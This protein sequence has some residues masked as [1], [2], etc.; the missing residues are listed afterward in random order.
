MSKC[1]AF[2]IL[3]FAM[4]DRS[5]NVCKTTALKPF[6]H[7]NCYVRVIWRRCC[8]FS[9]VIV[10]AYYGRERNNKPEVAS[11]VQD[12]IMRISTSERQ[13][14]RNW[15]ECRWQR[16]Q[17]NENFPSAERVAERMWYERR[18]HRSNGNCLSRFGFNNF[19]FT[20]CEATGSSSPF[21]PTENVH[22]EGRGKEVK[23]QQDECS[24]AVRKVILLTGGLFVSVFVRFVLIVTDETI[25]ILFERKT[26]RISD[27]CV[28]VFV[29]QDQH[30]FSPAKKK[31]QNLS[32]LKAMKQ[33]K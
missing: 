19:S 2:A 27:L 24:F 25:L 15:S 18:Q 4:V 31:G 26:K 17:I 28:F 33:Q 23:E 12:N 20:G 21:S 6:R 1:E 10:L 29:V 3:A 13:N 11:N 14:K 32:Q 5:E 8:P 9:R 30:T 22:N 7:Y 16:Q